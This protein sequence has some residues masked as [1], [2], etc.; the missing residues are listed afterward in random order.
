MVRGL[1]LASISRTIGM[2]KRLS[3]IRFL[4]KARVS[5]H[6]SRPETAFRSVDVVSVADANGTMEIEINGMGERDIK[7]TLTYLAQCCHCELAL[8]ASVVFPFG[9]TSRRE[10]E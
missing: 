4:K 8:A 3:L 5:M 10:Q 6:S 1:R 9:S 2:L 7:A